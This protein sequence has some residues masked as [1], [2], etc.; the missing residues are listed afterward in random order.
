MLEL[1]KSLPN[2]FFYNLTRETSLTGKGSVRFDEE[3]LQLL[4]YMPKRDEFEHVGTQK[5]RDR[6]YS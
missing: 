6:D 2:S 3:D 4:A 5:S 1:R